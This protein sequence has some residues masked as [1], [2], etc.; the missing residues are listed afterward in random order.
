MDEKKIKLIVE[1]REKKEKSTEKRGRVKRKEREKRGAEKKIVTEDMSA[2]AG[3]G[4]G[5][6]NRIKFENDA[7]SNK[8]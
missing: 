3:G 7:K 1:G 6:G 4:K 8:K 2:E 5:R